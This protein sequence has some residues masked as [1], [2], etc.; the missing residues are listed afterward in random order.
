MKT[1]SVFSLQRRKQLQ[2]RLHQ[3]L[4][5][6]IQVLSTERQQILCDDLVTALQ[7]RLIVLVKAE[8]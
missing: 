6:E 5:Q 1:G 8:A 4:K 7:N 2:T 3:A